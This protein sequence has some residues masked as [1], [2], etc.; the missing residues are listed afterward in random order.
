MLS[1]SA[2]SAFSAAPASSTRS[3]AR[4]LFG[5]LALLLLLAARPAR[6]THIVG[7][8]LDLRYLQN[9]DYQLSLNLYFDA[10]NGMPGALDT[11]LT[12]SIFERSTNRWIRDIVLP[13]TSNTFVN[14]TNPACTRPS[15]I[16]RK[17]L[18]SQQLTLPADT[19]SSAGGYYVAVERCC[20]N[21]TIS[22]IVRPGDAAQ[23]FYMEFPAVARQGQPFRDSTPRTFPPLGDYACLNELFYYDFGGQDPDGDSLIYDMVTPLNGYSTPTVPKPGRA[24]PAPYPP[25]QWKPQPA[26]QPP[27]SADNQIPGAPALGI[28]PHT[29]RLTVRPSQEGL[30]VFGVRCQEFRRGEK[31]GETRRDFQLYVLKCP[32]NAPPSELLSTDQPGAPAYRPG[33][34]TIRITATGSR[35]LRL[36]F[37]D[38]DPDSRL[39]ATLRPVN[40]TGVLPAFSTVASGV[41]RTPGAPDTLTATLCFPA[42]LDTKGKVFLLDVM[43]A[44]DGCSLPK[45]DT[46]RVAFIAAPAPNNPPTISS[47]AGP[48][49]PLHARVGDIVRFD[50]LATD[51]EGD[52]LTLQLS[53][54]AFN[55]AD[56]GATLSQTPTGKQI[57][58]HFEWKVDCRAVAPPGTAA[59]AREF[60]FTASSQPCADRQSALVTV[61]IIVD[62][63]NHAP[64]LT[65]TLPPA[66]ALPTDPPPL[67]RLTLGDS[68]TATFNGTDA[69]RDPLVLSA[70]GQGFELAAAGMRFT[71]LGGTGQASAVFRWDAT[72]EAVRL[73]KVLVVT[74]Q[75][76]ESTC[77]PQPQTRTVRFQV[78]SPD[79]IPFH[80]PN[81]ITPNGDDKNQYFTFDRS[82]SENP[83]LP[84]D[85]CDARFADVQIFSRWGQLVYKSADRQF[86]WAGQGMAG[87]YFYLITFTDGRKYKGWLD[88]MP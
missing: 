61:P 2:Q 26:G 74:F 50:V 38:P 3:G 42:C 48:S 81:I 51:P 64:Q 66:P 23:T 21:V 60:V 13:L 84:P 36:R 10:V 30:F 46:V 24:Q 41:V 16:T 43:V 52:P 76:Q 67:V 32:K 39:T 68:Y 79:S 75:L 25:V 78:L 49:L 58:G 18:Y 27:L 17:L 59:V 11:E 15:L 63:S 72:C 71:A 47:T 65:S 19:Y 9:N 8:E 62:Y 83:V 29:G 7:G 77:Q 85:F 87:S 34:D 57:Q 55:P 45:R 44:D 37:T 53:G 28:D 31:I 56:L 4:R 5:L 40:F 82:N 1:L 20:R 33:R 70:T 54:K 14:Y 69:D 35:C 12:A 22:N 86:K 88:V 73:Q 80:P 6:A